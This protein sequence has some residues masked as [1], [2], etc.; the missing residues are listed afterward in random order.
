MLIEANNLCRN[1][2]VSKRDSSFAS[3]VFKR[4]F[5][6]IKAVDNISFSIDTGE[7]VGFIGP[8]GAGKSTTIK[9]LCGLLAPSAGELRVFGKEPHKNR[10][11]IAKNIGVVFGQRSQLW[12]DLPLVDSLLLIKKIYQIPEKVYRKN[13]EKYSHILGLKEFIDQPVRQLSLGQR[14]RGDLCATL[15]HEPQILFLD[16]PTIGLD[17]IVKK[18]IRELIK[19]INEELNSTIILTTHDMKDVDEVCNRI[20]VMTTGKIVIDEAL[21]A[22]KK[23]FDNTHI[24]EVIFQDDTCPNV[25]S[26]AEI[27]EVGYR[28]CTYKIDANK[29]QL[30]AFLSLLVTNNKIADIKVKNNDIDDVIRALYHQETEV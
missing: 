22:V 4:K 21:S 5:E 6:T 12:W 11:D 24:V 30:G 23:Q 9:M 26:D 29:I 14:M 16:E 3:F 18:Q 25:F 20:I 2:R 13:L 8:N 19:E 10:K 15:L 28:T 7:I 17:I 1:Y 27:I